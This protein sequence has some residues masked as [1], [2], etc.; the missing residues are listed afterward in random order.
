[1]SRACRPCATSQV[2]E[3]DGGSSSPGRH[4]GT[5]RGDPGGHAAFCCI[6]E[7]VAGPVQ[8]AKRCGDRA[9]LS[10]S[11]KGPRVSTISSQKEKETRLVPGEPEP[12][13][14]PSPARGGSRRLCGAP[15]ACGPSSGPAP[16]SGSPRPRLP[17][18][19]PG[20]DIV[21]RRRPPLTAGSAGSAGAASRLPSPHGAARV[22]RIRPFSCFSCSKTGSGILP[23]PGE[24]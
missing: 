22:R 16:C 9:T 11:E 1:M 13:R 12:Q 5:G 10:R 7:E 17:A 15:A 24:P 8:D 19:F 21:A 23:P 14:P 2:S 6:R 20:Y 18:C 3:A 4:P